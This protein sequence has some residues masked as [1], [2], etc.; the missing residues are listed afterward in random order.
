MAT[1][2]Q[3]AEQAMRILAGGH[4][5]PDRTMDIREVMLALDQFRDDAVRNRTLANINNGE[6]RIDE[7][8][9]SFYES[10]AV[11]TDSTKGIKY[12]TLPAKPID[13]P[14]NLG[15]YQISPTGNMEDPWIITLAGA[16]GIYTGTQAL[17]HELKTYCWQ[18]G[19]RVYVKNIDP[20]IA[21]V[22][23]LMA[24]TSKGIAESATY[25]VPPDVEAELLQKVIQLFSIE[26]QTPH[27]ELEDGQK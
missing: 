3:I 8:F 25:P 21:E 15:L 23:V 24:T 9:L 14:K 6:I 16:V 4:I 19:E 20:S 27:D 17:E 26:K 11:A 22:T 1:K 10:I 7:E 18:V 2:K 12:I 5:K 13:L